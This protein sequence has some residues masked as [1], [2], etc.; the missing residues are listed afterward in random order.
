MK[1]IL[2]GYKNIS[3]KK[4]NLGTILRFK[5]SVRMTF[6]NESFQILFRLSKIGKEKDM[7]EGDRQNIALEW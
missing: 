2:F 5:G 6:I 3:G 4:E 7:G 1:I